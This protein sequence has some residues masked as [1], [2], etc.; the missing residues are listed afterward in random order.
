MRLSVCYC[1]P[2]VVTR[3]FRVDLSGEG[4]KATGLL[5]RLWIVKEGK[6]KWAELKEPFLLSFYTYLSNWSFLP[7]IGLWR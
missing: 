1:C 2:V 5:R 6:N 7:F 4:R 3:T